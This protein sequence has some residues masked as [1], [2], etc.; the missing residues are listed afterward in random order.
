MSREDYNLPA[1]QPVLLTTSPGPT[2]VQ[3]RKLGFRKSFRQIGLFRSRTFPYVPV[4]KQTNLQPPNVGSSTLHM[5][6]FLCFQLFS[7]QNTQ[8]TENNTQL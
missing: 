7:T 8:R 4:L 6:A 5:S 3:K 2:F 1:L